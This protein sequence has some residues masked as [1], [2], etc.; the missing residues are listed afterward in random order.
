MEL[1]FQNKEASL[2]LNPI[3]D[4]GLFRVG[5]S[6]DL[7]QREKHPLI[8][9]KHIATLLVSHYHNQ[10][11]HQRC[12]FIDGAI[13]AAGFWIIGHKYLLFNII[14]NCVIYGKLRGTLQT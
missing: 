3:I 5:G 2:T 6:S 9:Q 11:A 1:S 13:I 14:H 8:I 10:V 7:S 12:H 4:D